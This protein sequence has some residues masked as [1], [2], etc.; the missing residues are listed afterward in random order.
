MSL[1][2]CTCDVLGMPGN[3]CK[4][5]PEMNTVTTPT[6]P[7]VAR[8]D[9]EYFGNCGSDCETRAE[10]RECGGGDYV[11]IESYD[12]LAA[13]CERLRR[14]LHAIVDLSKNDEGSYTYNAVRAHSM[15]MTAVEALTTTGKEPQQ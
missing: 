9:L 10:M 2:P 14:A 3:R 4:K 1:Y 5:H 11:K 13:E 7:P 15:K 6:P 12:R 8:Y